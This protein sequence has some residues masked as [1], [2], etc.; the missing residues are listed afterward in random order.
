MIINNDCSE[1]QIKGSRS[2]DIIK[3]MIILKSKLR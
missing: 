1:K 2:I 3:I